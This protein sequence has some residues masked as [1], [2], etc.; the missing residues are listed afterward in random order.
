MKFRVYLTF[1][2]IIMK[3]VK[4]FALSLLT[5]AFLSGCTIIP[6]SNLTTSN[7][8]YVPTLENQ[9]NYLS[10]IKIYHITP[11]LL[12]KMQL[13]PIQ[14]QNNP[15]L[16]KQLQNYQYR[17]EP[18]DILS[19]TVW[20]HPELTIPAGSYRSANESGNWVRAD[21][22]IFYPYIGLLHVAGKT[23]TQIRVMIAT[24]LAAYIEHPQVDV[25]ISAFRSQKIYMTGAV[26]N[27]SQQP[28]TNVPLT[29]LGAINQAGGLKPNADWNDVT[30][31]YNGHQQTVSL[32]ALM[33][34]GDLMDNR[35]LQSGDII[36]IPTDVH[37]KVFVL[38]EVKDPKV[39]KIGHAGLTLTGAL[40]SVGGLNQLS[41]DA[42]GVFVIRSAQRMH[43]FGVLK[44]EYVKNKHPI[45]TIYQLNIKDATALVLGTEFQ[46]QPYDIVY[47]TAAPIAL[48]NRVL[49]N[50][51]PSISGLNDLTS[52]S[53][54]IRN[55]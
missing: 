50:L 55:L 51:M 47:V 27:P 37:Q 9:S 26:K 40:S 41:A 30:I 42:T 21:G 43:H 38:G 14:A 4:I 36:H 2:L 19:V 22:N 32:Y 53:Y 7:K 15:K 8:E 48:W 35:L 20:D 13:A 39:L 25:N 5:P 23:L 29:L 17:V 33:E 28:I 34:R 31:T 1:K 12:E 10:N 45:A 6:G 46:L 54:N 16:E 18:G 3:L 44:S 24:R 52:M 11:S 49:N